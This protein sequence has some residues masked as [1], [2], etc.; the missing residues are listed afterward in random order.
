MLREVYPERSERAQN[1]TR[2]FSAASKTAPFGRVSVCYSGA[3]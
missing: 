1:D 3:L 2:P